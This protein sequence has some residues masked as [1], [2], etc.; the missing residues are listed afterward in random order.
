MDGLG[1]GRLTGAQ[2]LLRC[3]SLSS[4]RLG[5]GQGLMRVPGFNRNRARI[6]IQNS[7]L[8]QEVTVGV[9][10]S[11]D[12]SAFSCTRES[13]SVTRFWRPRDHLA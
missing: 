8:N 9:A 13:R 3:A 1:E 4:A 11:T 12:Q 10:P 5:F 6:P 7:G 2:Y